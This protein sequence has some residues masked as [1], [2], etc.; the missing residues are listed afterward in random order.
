[1]VSDKLRLLPAVHEVADLLR[2][3]SPAY[4]DTR[5]TKAARTA[6]Q[7]V[8]LRILDGQPTSVDL[9][10]ILSAALQLLESSC[11]PSQ[12]VNA[13][14]V[15]LH[16]NL[17]RA[18]LSESAIAAVCTAAKSSDLEYDLGSG[19]RASRNR[20]LSDPIS[21]LTNTEAGFIVNNCA[22]ALVLAL[23]SLG[24][25]ATALARS[26]IIEIGGGF[27][28]PDI[29]KASGVQLME[30]G[31]TNRTR[32]SDY[33]EALENGASAILWMHRS[34]FEIT[35]FT[36]EP[37]LEE[38]RQVADRFQVPLIYDLGTGLKWDTSTLNL[39]PE[40]TI[41][42]KAV[43]LADV[44][45]FSGDKLFGGPQ[46][47]VLVGKASAIKRLAK[48]PLAR[49][50]R[51]DKLTMAAFAATLM[52]HLN[53]TPQDL[54]TYQM[55]NITLAE[56]SERAQQVYSALPN[57]HCEVVEVS[58]T[59]GGGTMPNSKLPGLAIKLTTLDTEHVHQRLRSEPSPIVARIQDDA[60]LLHLRTISP[61]QID[62]V[63]NKLRDILTTT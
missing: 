1:M 60:V 11:T 4:S 38:L 52:S 47:G 9:E 37:T 2:K 19:N 45:L 18:P 25:K 16:T 27:R 21:Q 48:H 43:Q 30:V 58:D 59:V 22:A 34:N 63:I 49:A 6:I 23:A 36:Q 39:R 28:L 10:S 26:Q 62:I 12:V 56:L 55:L 61:Q 54:P 57:D 31:T 50:L 3:R 7:D 42:D 53:E 13:T 44:T 35:G 41:S 8:R 40:P 17:G 15:I 20:L 5:L 32:L 33:E 24:G 46:A 51:A 14:G 29:M